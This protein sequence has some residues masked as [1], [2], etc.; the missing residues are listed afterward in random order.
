VN[1]ND[2]EM[3]E[4]LNNM[5]ERIMTQQRMTYETTLA[6]QL[7]ATVS[8]CGGAIYLVGGVVL[9]LQWLQVLAL[10]MIA[11]GIYIFSFKK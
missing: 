3:L 5:I 1:K 2:E 6:K 11:Y 7:S 9:E 8:M 4:A 10:C